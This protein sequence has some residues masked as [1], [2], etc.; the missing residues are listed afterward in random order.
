MNNI[1]CYN[2]T[3][4]SVFPIF[5]TQF[6]LYSILFT[7][8]ALSSAVGIGGGGLFIP[9]FL[10]LSD[11]NLKT[12]IPYVVIS[13]FSNSLVRMFLLIPKNHIYND[14]YKL[15]DYYIA[16]QIMCFNAAGSYI[17]FY[18]NRIIEQYILKIV[19]F[20]L[21]LTV[22][23]KTLY[24]SYKMFH[25][26]KK[27]KNK[28]NAI[29]IDGISIIIPKID[30][31]V[32]NNNATKISLN[33]T[34][35]MILLYQTIFNGFFLLRYL[36]NNNIIIIISQS[37]F[38]FCSG[39]YVSYLNYRYQPSI[40]FKPTI[41]S[42]V[43]LSGS[44][45]CIGILSTMLGI[46]G[47]MLLSPLLLSLKIDSNVV[48]ATNSMTTFFSS[49]TSSLQYIIIG[50]MKPDFILLFISLSS[51]S[52]KIGLSYSKKI[53]KKCSSTWPL[54][55]MLGILIITASILIILT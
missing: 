25:I 22:G 21:L 54:I 49:L 38:S 29:Y 3:I 33:K 15:I 44:G 20:I 48:M 9:V 41:H 1:T 40:N 43:L 23:L 37:L 31:I 52:S 6:L 12:I 8:G 53:N 32:L 4:E 51:I 27:N 10:L 45:L 47:G 34:K 16:S 17:G 46:G 5:P 11:F 35:G 14:N 24:K 42:I 26:F 55:L 39:I 7:F 2:N 28:N 19:I 30:D 50:N 13:I 36:F 18:L